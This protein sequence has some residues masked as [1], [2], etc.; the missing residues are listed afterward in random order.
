LRA[1]NLEATGDH[2]RAMADFNKA[3]EI[4]PKY[5]YAYI[6]RGDA[7]KARGQH[8]KAVA[9]F[10]KAIAIDPNNAVAYSNRAASYALTGSN[11]LAIADYKAI[12][13]RPAVT[14]AERQSQE[15]ARQRIA[16]LTLMSGTPANASTSAPK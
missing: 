4:N 12:V 2:D 7:L 15:F 9:D 13:E 3:I 1:R 8:D 14:A 10:T 6:F 5:Y 11:S 16:Q